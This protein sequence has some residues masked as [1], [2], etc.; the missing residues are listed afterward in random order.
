MMTLAQRRAAVALKWREQD[1]GGKKEIS[2]MRGF[3]LLIR[4]E[5][6]LLA[7]A[8]AIERKED[9]QAKQLLPKNPGEMLLAAALVEHLT[10]EG[11][12]K[13]SR[14][15]DDMVNEL[16]QAADPAQLRRATAESLA[17]LNYLRRLIA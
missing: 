6:L 12:L 9:K 13:Q 14:T 2:A 8:F 1:L 17:F 4:M 10:A 5:G 3:P 16:A 15:P 7:L 11:I